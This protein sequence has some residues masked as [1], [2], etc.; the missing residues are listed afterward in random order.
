M[1]KNYITYKGTIH[2]DPVNKTK[3]H[4]S[5]ADWKRM[6]LIMFDGE[7]VGELTQADATEQA[8]GLM[9]AGERQDGM[10]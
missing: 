2:F 10:A 6:A 5:Q 7:I 9:M 4:E 3:K 1:K 8:L